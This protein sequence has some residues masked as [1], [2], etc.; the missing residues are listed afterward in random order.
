MGIAPRRY[1][2]KIKLREQRL[3]RRWSLRK[4]S[5]FSGIAHG[6]LSELERGKYKN[7]SVLV[8]CRIAKALGCKIDDLIECERDD[9]I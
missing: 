5:I 2:M 4:L 7:P 1:S 6:Y 3:R 8:L 9:Y